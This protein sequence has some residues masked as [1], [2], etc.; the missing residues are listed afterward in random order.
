[1]APFILRRVMMNKSL[2]TGVGTTVL[3][4]IALIMS[5]VLPAAAIGNPDAPKMFPMGLSLLLMVL[6]II[7]IV[8]SYINRSNKSNEHIDIREMIQNETN[9]M[10]G[11][12]CLNCV[13][14]ALIYNRAGYLISTIV[15]MSIM[16]LLFNGKK[17]WKTNTIVSVLFSVFIYITFT[18]F[19]GVVLPPIPGLGI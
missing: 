1:M 4:L 17:N 7:M 5:Y 6:G 2:L 13:L 8:Q 14:Y 10:I 18:K 16:L 15:F 12:T 11:F 3:G 19:L 9:R